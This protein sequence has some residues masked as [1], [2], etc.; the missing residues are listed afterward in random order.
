MDDQLPIFIILMALSSLTRPACELGLIEDYVNL[1][2]QGTES[3]FMIITT[4]NASIDYIIKT[5][6][7]SK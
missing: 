2:S 4:L 3:V 6:G 7:K 1:E 5:F